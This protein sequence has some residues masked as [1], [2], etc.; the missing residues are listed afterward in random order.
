MEQK[1]PPY[2]RLKSIINEGNEELTHKASKNLDE[3]LEINNSKTT[4]LSNIKDFFINIDKKIFSRTSIYS[5]NN[6]RRRK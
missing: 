5:G 4:L 3:I 2:Q 1:L 6:R